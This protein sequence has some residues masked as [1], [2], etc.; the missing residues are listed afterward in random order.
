L[1]S[2][3]KQTNDATAFTGFTSASDV[4]PIS[5]VISA[6]VGDMV[7]GA[8][9]MAAGNFTS[10]TGTGVLDNTGSSYAAAAAYDNGAAPTKT[11]TAFPGNAT[12]AAGAGICV[13]AA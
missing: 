10:T 4:A 6:A 9:G 1:F 12:Y 7:V 11:V 2:G 5:L 13:K 3:V 8:F